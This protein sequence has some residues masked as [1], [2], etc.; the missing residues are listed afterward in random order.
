MEIQD[1]LMT[2]SQVGEATGLPAG[3]LYAMVARKM[4]PH[5]RLG[6]RLVRF[7]R[8]ELERWLAERSVA[9]ET[10]VAS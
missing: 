1:D 6:K 3:T 5:L 9:V 8:V 10:G 7:R 2:Y 4:I